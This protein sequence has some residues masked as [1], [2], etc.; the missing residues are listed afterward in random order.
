MGKGIS[1]FGRLPGANGHT[2]TPFCFEGVEYPST[3]FLFR[4]TFGINKP[5]KVFSPPSE[6]INILLILFLI[7]IISA[8]FMEEQKKGLM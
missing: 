3:K 6:G 4:F 8:P 2:W 5:L 7:S 1:V